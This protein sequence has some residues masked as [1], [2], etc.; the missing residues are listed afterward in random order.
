ML[1][2]S[3]WR[4]K[5]TFS[6]M[7]IKTVL[8]NF[9]GKVSPQSLMKGNH[10]CIIYLSPGLSSPQLLVDDL[11]QDRA[12]QKQC[13]QDLR[14]PETVFHFCRLATAAAVLPSSYAA[15][16]HSVLSLDLGDHCH[17][18]AGAWG[19]NKHQNRYIV[20]FRDTSLILSGEP[21]ECSS[22]VSIG[23]GKLPCMKS[24]HIEKD[25]LK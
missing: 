20:H 9:E 2:S 1:V 16:S 19:M 21:R 11:R 7:D 6:K 13:H 12:G 4:E 17:G 23:V 25:I 15:Y 14:P 3:I 8:S 5:G 24:S 10:S 22:Q 18:R